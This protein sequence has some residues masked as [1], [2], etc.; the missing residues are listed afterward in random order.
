MTNGIGVNSEWVAFMTA[1]EA[2]EVEFAH[3]R[4]EAFKALWSHTDEVTLCG[5]FG[6]LVER[7]WKHVAAQLDWASSKFSNGTRCTEK[8]SGMVGAD[9]AYLV[10][11]ELIKFRVAGRSDDSTLEL[12]VTMIFSHEAEGWRITHRHADS[13]VS[14]QV[15]E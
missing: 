14:S 13:Q 9:F 1:L 10:Q 4:S 11:K 2:A 3:G 15:P 7:G 6:G 5:G 8:I 12:R